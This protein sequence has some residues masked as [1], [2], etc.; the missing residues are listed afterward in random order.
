MRQAK[1]EIYLH[2]VWGTWQRQPLVTEDI[3]RALYRCIEK[4]V[5]RLKC[6]VLAIG[7]VPDHVHLVVRMHTTVS[8]SGLAQQVKGVSSTFVRDSLRRGDLFGWQDGYGVFS[9]S[10]NHVKRV[11]SY[12]QDQKRRHEKHKVW[13]EW[14]DTDEEYES[15]N[16]EASAT[17]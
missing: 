17:A 12:V 7:G 13:D 9:I 6:V 11:I 14:E 1:A 15:R 5:K 8:A 10:R 3:E 4:E 16:T 2:M